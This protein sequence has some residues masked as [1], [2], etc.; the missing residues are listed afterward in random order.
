MAKRRTTATGVPD[1][2]REAVER[3]I[4][5]TVGSAQETRGRGQKAVD[6]IVKGAETGV[7]AVRERVRGA[8]ESGRPATYE[9]IRDLQT[10]LRAI[11][12]RLDAIEERL[13]AKRAGTSSA[14]RRRP[15]TKRSGPKKSSK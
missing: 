13:P 5:A 2:V 3:T 10:E 7:G 4:Q 12:R 11:G 1:A 6:D 15:A 14:A 9:D 8:I